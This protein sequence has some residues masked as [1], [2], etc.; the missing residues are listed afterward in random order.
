MSGECVICYARR[1][2][3]SLRCVS[4]HPTCTACIEKGD[5]LVVSHTW[6][7]YRFTCPVCRQNT[8]DLTTNLTDIRLA[9]AVIKSLQKCDDSDSDED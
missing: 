7:I 4:G 3:S 2:K 8:Y 5:L 6:P 9:R 1:P